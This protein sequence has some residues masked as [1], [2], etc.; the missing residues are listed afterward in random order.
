MTPK[1]ARNLYPQT[2]VINT[3]TQAL[4]VVQE[5]G[6]WS[7]KIDWR[8]GDVNGLVG[9]FAFNNLSNVRIY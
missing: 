2:V 5:I 6:Q 4:G 8:A 3:N 7:V 1:E 9:W